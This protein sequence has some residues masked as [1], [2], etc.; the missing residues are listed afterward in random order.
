MNTAYGRR[1]EQIFDI[2]HRRFPIAYEAKPGSDTATV[3]QELAEQLAEAIRARRKADHEHLGDLLGSL[4]PAGIDVILRF[5]GGGTFT[6][7]KPQTMGN[8]VATLPEA[9]A[10]ERFV[11]LGII[12]YR[13]PTVVDALEGHPGSFEWTHF[14]QMLIERFRRS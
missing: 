7:G 14:G 6:I 8:V 2:K 1:D 12:S 4:G 13:P 5:G 3:V 11:Q 10:I 9:L